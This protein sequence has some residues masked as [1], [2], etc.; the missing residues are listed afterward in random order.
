VKAI[1]LGLMNLLYSLQPTALRFV[2]LELLFI[3]LEIPVE[4]NDLQLQLLLLC[5]ILIS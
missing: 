2:A 5:S 1:Q 3:S 4:F